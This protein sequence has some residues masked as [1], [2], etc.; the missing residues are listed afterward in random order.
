MKAHANSL[1]RPRLAEGENLK[2]DIIGKLDGM[3]EV[4]GMVEER[5]PQIRCRVP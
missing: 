3:L 1:Y 4:V 2:K 5:S